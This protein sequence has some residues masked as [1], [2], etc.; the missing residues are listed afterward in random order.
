MVPRHCN[1][2]DVLP[3][4][5]L[6]EVDEAQTDELDGIE[7]VD[8]TCNSHGTIAV[9]ENGIQQRYVE[10]IQKRVQYECSCKFGAAT[11]G[12]LNDTK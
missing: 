11:G 1:P 3:N 4:C 8:V 12:A 2:N 6:D 9:T 10:G 5:D 7:E